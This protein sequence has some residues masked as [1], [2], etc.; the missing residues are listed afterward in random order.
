MNELITV[1]E[2]SLVVFN[3]KELNAVQLFEQEEIAKIVETV[4]TELSKEVFDV[5]EDK[6]RKE[7]QKRFKQIHK[8]S[9]LLDNVGKEHVA[10]LK[11]RPKIVDGNRKYMRDELEG[12]ADKIRQPLT[13]WE[14]AEEQRKKDILARINDIDPFLGGIVTIQPGERSTESLKALAEKA[15]LTEID[16]S[17]AEFQGQAQKTKDDAILKLSG[18]I[19]IQMRQEAEAAALEQQRK[20]QEAK[21]QAEREARIAQEAA[22][23]A[24]REAEEKAAEERQALELKAEKERQEAIRR[25]RE[26]KE[27]QERAEREK[28]AAEER[29]KLEQEQAVKAEQERHRKEME[30]QKA[31]EEAERKAAEKK[32]ANKQHRAKINNNIVL[33]LFNHVGI[34]ET[35]AK[36]LVEAIAKGKIRNVTIN[37]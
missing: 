13:E 7:L 36:M 24:R 28:I 15:A 21:E 2:N 34:P 37:Y 11:S 30:A 20:E 17:F 1:N 26:A 31:K 32:A 35:T 25:E 6:G 8:W 19:A 10:V 18:L 22:D 12:F 9:K 27:A 33:D 29:A 14:Q 16:E 3:N 4:K 5:S 23:K